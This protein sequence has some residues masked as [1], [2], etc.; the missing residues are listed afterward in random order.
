M[1]KM[2]LKGQAICVRQVTAKRTRSKLPLSDMA[3]QDMGLGLGDF[4]HKSEG[5]L[6][7]VY[8]FYSKYSVKILRLRICSKMFPLYT[9]YA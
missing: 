9:R 2:A 8:I 5:F 1:K 4:H 7:L 3:W 6:V